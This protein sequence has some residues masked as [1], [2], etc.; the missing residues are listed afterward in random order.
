MA[1]TETNSGLVNEITR[2]SFRI[3]VKLPSLSTE[4]KLDLIGALSLLNQ[5]LVLASDEDETVK[6]QASKL[7]QLAKRISK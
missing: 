7:L 1:E 3:G 6:K 4:D 5:A 2:L